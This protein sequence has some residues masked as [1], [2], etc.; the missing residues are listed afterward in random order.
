MKFFINSFHLSDSAVVDRF[1]RGLAIHPDGSSGGEFTGVAP[2]GVRV[3]IIIV[4]MAR[5][6]ELTTQLKEVN[7]CRLKSTQAITR[8]RLE[9]AEDR[10]CRTVKARS[11]VKTVDALVEI[12]Q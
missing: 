12:H 1:V 11:L 3:L 7:H 8:S 9:S 2:T 6:R 5:F 10:R 4:L